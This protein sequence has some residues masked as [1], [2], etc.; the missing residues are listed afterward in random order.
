MFSSEYMHMLVERVLTGRTRRKIIRNNEK[1]AHLTAA[2]P[3]AAPEPPRD[4]SFTRPKVLLL[5]PLRSLALHY[6]TSHLP[7]APHGTQIENMRPFMSSFS[8]PKNTE[9]PLASTSATTEY[10]LDHLVNFRGNSDD[11]FRIGIKITRKAWRVVMMPANED[12]LMECDII[13]ASPL[14]IKMQSEREE[15]TDLLSSIE[16]VVVDG[17]DV[18]Q[19]QN[20]DHVQVSSLVHTFSP[21]LMTVH[22]LPPQQNAQ[23]TSWM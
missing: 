16:V 4:Q 18:M 10:P 20:W 5:L 6:L 17:I 7:L 12:K 3:T 11:N 14:G 2:D 15:S 21:M 23:I 19:M 1:L 13:I 22:I 9:D 8:I